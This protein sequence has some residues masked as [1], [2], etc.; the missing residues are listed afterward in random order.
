MGEA[1]ASDAKGEVK[2]QESKG[3]DRGGVQLPIDLV[4]MIRVITAHRNISA[5][6]LVEPLVRRGIQEEYRKVKQELEDEP[7]PPFANEIG[8]ES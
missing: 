5:K 7:E 4:R 3:P 1:T 2:S 8:G 6:A